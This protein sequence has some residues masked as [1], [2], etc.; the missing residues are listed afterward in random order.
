MPRIVVLDGYTLNPGDNPWDPVAAM[1]ELTVHDRT[2]PPLIVERS[3]G[4]EIVLTNKTP[5]TRETISALPEL[6]MIGVLAT[7]YNIV[8]IPAA[9][10]RGILVC[11]VPEYGSTTVAQFTF[12]LILELCHQVGAHA[13]SV[14]SGQWQRNS[15]WC[16]WNSPQVELAGKTLGIVGFGRIGRNVGHIGHAMGMRVIAFDRVQAN[17]PGYQPFAFKSLDEL[18]AESDILTLHCPQ[19]PQNTG[20]INAALLSRMKP[21]AFLINASRGGLV[22]EPDLADALARGAIAAA[23]VDVVSTEPIQ[24]DNPLLGARNCLITPHMAWAT[25]EARRRI[26]ATTADNIAAFLGGSPR[27]V[28]NP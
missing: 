11:N 15:D 13:Q 14:K 2:P 21:T 10:E 5:L 8:D 20:M 12:A 26:M 7:G 3:A 6:R 4:R 24:P 18:V 19:T 25:L 27:N 1:G 9:R 17:P 22:S 28:V 23:A 16:Y